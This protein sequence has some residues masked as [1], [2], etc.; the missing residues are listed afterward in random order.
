MRAGFTKDRQ[1]GSHLVM[2]HPDTKALT[3]IPVHSRRT[4]K[5]PLLRAIIA[6]AKL[7]VDDF[8][9]LV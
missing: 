9:R 2:W 3:V 1:R 5:K 7:T 4:I 6:D 8:L